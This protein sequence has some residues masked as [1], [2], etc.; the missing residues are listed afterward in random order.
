MYRRL[1]NHRTKWLLELWVTYHTTPNF[2]PSTVKPTHSVTRGTKELLDNGHLQDAVAGQPFSYPRCLWRSRSDFVLPR[3]RIL[4][5]LPAP[6]RSFPG[7]RFAGLTSWYEFYYEI[8]QKGQMTF[9]I[10]DL[11]KEY[12]KLVLVSTCRSD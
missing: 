9:H 5:P 11:H 2:V 1:G 3:R 7:P 10:Q 8:V 12:G 4:P 6:H